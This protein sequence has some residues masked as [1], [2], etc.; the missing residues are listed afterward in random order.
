MIRSCWSGTQTLCFVC[1]LSTNRRWYLGT[2]V[3]MLAVASSLCKCLMLYVDLRPQYHGT[4]VWL[5]AHDL[6]KVWQWNLRVQLVYFYN[7]PSKLSLFN[8][9]YFT[10]KNHI[11]LRVVNS[12]LSN[13][14][15][16]TLT[17]NLRIAQYLTSSLYSRKWHQ[18]STG[19]HNNFS[20]T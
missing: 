4:V 16:G 7:W 18:G 3:H 13:K 9:N 11:A 20:C 17:H 10:L 14:L 19:F 12:Q 2:W 15:P 6:D 8:C 5:R 1:S